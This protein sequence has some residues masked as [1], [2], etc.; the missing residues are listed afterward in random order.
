MHWMGTQ[1][2]IIFEGQ[3]VQRGAVSPRRKRRGAE[4]M[5]GA[6]VDSKE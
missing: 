2:C 1:R 3:N 5:A 4:K 6:A